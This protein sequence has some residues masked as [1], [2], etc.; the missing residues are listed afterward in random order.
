MESPLAV[1][2][3]RVLTKAERRNELWRKIKKNKWIYLMIAPG[4]LYFFVYKYI[5][6]YGLVIAFQDYKLLRDYWE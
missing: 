2:K 5:P 3:K 6:M 4:I 1:G